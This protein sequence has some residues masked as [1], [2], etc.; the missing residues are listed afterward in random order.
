MVAV[1]F[2]AQLIKGG[3]GDAGHD[4]LNFHKLSNLA[5]LRLALPESEQ[6]ESI[7]DDTRQHCLR[8]T[9]HQTDFRCSRY[10]GTDNY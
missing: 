7:V 8:R 9:N 5:Q 1:Y 10:A 4:V 6:A 2:G 3:G